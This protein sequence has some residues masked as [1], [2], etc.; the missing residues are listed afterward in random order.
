MTMTLRSEEEKDF[1]AVENLTRE[2]FWNLYRPGCSE[3]Y[4]L[5][6]FRRSP[7]VKRT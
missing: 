6:Q 3:H 7:G 2:A 1:R 4:V 5:H